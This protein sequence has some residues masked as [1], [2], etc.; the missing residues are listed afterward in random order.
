ML[1]NYIDGLPLDITSRLLP[2]RTWFRFA[3]LTHIHLHAKSQKHYEAK[4]RVATRRK[5]SLTAFR[6]LV[7]SLE[8]FIKKLSLPR[9]QSEWSDYYDHTNYTS[10]AFEHKLSL[11]DE[12]LER[13][14]PAAVW[15]LGANIGRFSRLAAAGNIPT[16]AFDMDP[17]AVEKNYLTVKAEKEKN[18]LPLL[19]DLTN[20]SPGLGWENHER[21][22]LIE[23]GPV[24]AVMALALIHHL[25]VTNNLPLEYIARFLSNTCRWLII[26]FIPKTDSQVN[27]LLA[28]RKDIFENYTRA[29]FES[30]FSCFFIVE[31]SE[32]LPESERIL[33]LMRK[34]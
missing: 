4:P 34:K 32:K 11:V 1:R 26:E 6:G 13:A 3:L 15:D 25:A 14:K 7:D 21:Q 27:R 12:F 20:P 28:G 33:Y 9:R 22:S 31:R 8:S 18:I 30:T 24:D 5:M 2:S 16:I 23:R 19:A 10:A 29:A 17:Y